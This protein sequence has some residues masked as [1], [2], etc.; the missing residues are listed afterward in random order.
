MAETSCPKYSDFV[1]TN[2]VFV[3]NFIVDLFHDAVYFHQHMKTRN[4][5]THCT[6]IIPDTHFQAPMRNGAG[7][8]NPEYCHDPAALSLVL[9]I[10]A[11]RCP[12]RIIHLGD[13]TEM[14]VIS[15]WS[16]SIAR[17][18]QVKGEDGQWHAASW[19]DSMKM[20]TSFWRYLDRV[21]PQAEKN[22]LEGNHDFWADLEF[23][24]PALAPFA[25]Q[26]HIRRLP[27]W[28]ELGIRYHPYDGDQ[29]KDQPWVDA[30]RVRVLHGYKNVS[31]QRMRLEHDNVVYGHQHKI[32]YNSWDA[33]S[34]E[35]R[36]AWCIGC[37]TKLKPDYNSRGGAQNGWAQGFGVVYALPNK[38]FVVKVVEIQDGCVVDFD[39]KTYYAKPL[40][41]VGRELKVLEL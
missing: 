16:K 23:S 37:L 40:R 15:A 24:T 2:A 4:F 17:E 41:R 10:A 20:V 3:Q 8:V 39:G 19:E 18:G 36:R 14:A 26:L 1:L 32:L 28:K 13:I 12:D 6:F 21:H 34:R 30:G 35:M 31:A 7:L 33:S 38:K 5:S 11:E 22:Q 25:D 27:V 9:Q 29:K